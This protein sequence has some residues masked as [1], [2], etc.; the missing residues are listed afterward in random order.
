VHVYTT[1]VADGG[2]TVDADIRGFAIRMY[3]HIIMM[4]KECTIS[5]KEDGGSSTS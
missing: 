3:R 1:N 4:L 5:P 2:V